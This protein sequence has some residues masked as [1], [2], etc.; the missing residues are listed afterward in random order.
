FKIFFVKGKVDHCLGRDKRRC[1]HSKLYC[2]FIVSGCDASMA[3][4]RDPRQVRLQCTG[5]TRP[6]H[7][8]LEYALS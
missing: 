1:R 2:E 4:K 8:L 5:E 7:S 3:E 6:S